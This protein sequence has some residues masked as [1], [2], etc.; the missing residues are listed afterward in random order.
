M[1]RVPPNSRETRAGAG[2]DC[3]VYEARFEFNPRSHTEQETE[4]SHA[5]VLH[6][7]DAFLPG[8]AKIG[9]GSRAHRPDLGS[10]QCGQENRY[11]HK[12]SGK[13]SSTVG[14][15]CWTMIL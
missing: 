13:S 6:Q 11:S 2:I 10:S 8:E 1:A 4:S 7:S 14:C 3:K 5:W 15:G 9:T 12:V